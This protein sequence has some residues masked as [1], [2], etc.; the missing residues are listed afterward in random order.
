[1]RNVA[2]NKQKILKIPVNM[3]FHIL[4]PFLLNSLAELINWIKLKSI[5][6]V[7]LKFWFYYVLKITCHRIKEYIKKNERTA[8][9]T[10]K[11]IKG[12]RMGSIATH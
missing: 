9:N 1:M 7:P 6:F 11:P 4:K 2:F 10:R 5:K 3:C 8:K 12:C